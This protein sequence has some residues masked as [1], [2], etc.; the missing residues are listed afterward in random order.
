MI[1]LEL[2]QPN[3]FFYWMNNWIEIEIKD[4]SSKIRMLHLQRSYNFYIEVR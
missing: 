4:G 1:S 3:I 2:S